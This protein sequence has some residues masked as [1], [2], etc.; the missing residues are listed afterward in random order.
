MKS[1]EEL[2]SFNVELSEW[3][4][5]LEIIVG[6]VAFGLAVGCLGINNNYVAFLASAASIFVCMKLTSVGVRHFPSELV[7]LRGKNKKTSTDN[8]KLRVLEP[9]VRSMQTPVYSFGFLCLIASA[10]FS[11]FSILQTMS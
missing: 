9:Q 4:T 11:G 2:D 8:A 10:A 6:S 3:Q 7:K 1:E 5:H